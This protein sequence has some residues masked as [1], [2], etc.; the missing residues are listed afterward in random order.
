[1]S[2][3]FS[4]ILLIFPQIV[5]VFG[6]FFT[7]FVN[8]PVSLLILL[9][10]CKI[11]K[12]YLENFYLNTLQYYPAL[13]KYFPRSM[14]QL[15]LQVRSNARGKYFQYRLKNSYCNLFY[16]DRLKTFQRE[17]KLYEFEK[18]RVEYK[19][20]RRRL[21]VA[22]LCNGLLCNDTTSPCNGYVAFRKPVCKY[23]AF[24]S[25]FCLDLQTKLASFL[26][27]CYS[28]NNSPLSRTS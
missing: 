11:S 26:T 10:C 22:L 19:K 8:I 7:R 21:A 4:Q 6:K 15:S 1:M 24:T 9:L 25:P 17:T 12:N 13:L 28:G 20:T 3:I 2:T 14:Y 18:G 16:L 5:H 23:F 27:T